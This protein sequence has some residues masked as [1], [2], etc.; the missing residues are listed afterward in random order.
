[1]GQAKLKR[2]AEAREEVV[3]QALAAMSTRVAS[4]HPSVQFMVLDVHRVDEARARLSGLPANI[5]SLLSQQQQA[6]EQFAAVL[7]WRT[8]E[9]FEQAVPISSAG[10][11]AQERLVEFV[12]VSAHSRGYGW[13][14][15]NFLSEEFGRQI[16][17]IRTAADAELKPY[18]AAVA[19]EPALRYATVPDMECFEVAHSTDS[20]RWMRQSSLLIRALDRLSA[21]RRLFEERFASVSISFTGHESDAREIFEIEQGASVIR[22]VVAAVGHW[23]WF[24]RPEESVLWI[25]ALFASGK[26]SVNTRRE[27]SFPVDVDA[28]MRSMHHESFCLTSVAVS[29]GIAADSSLLAER[30]EQI[31]RTQVGILRMLDARQRALASGRDALISADTLIQEVQQQNA[32][33]TPLKEVCTILDRSSIGKLGL[34][35][36]LESAGAFPSAEVKAA[37]LDWESSAAP[38]AVIRRGTTPDDGWSVEHISDE[39]MHLARA[40]DGLLMSSIQRRES[41]SWQLLVSNEMRTKLQS[42]T[43]PAVQRLMKVAGV[44]PH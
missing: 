25:G 31:A 42:S 7:W 32:E 36:L 39:G 41:L 3:R 8:P 34:N 40:V 1:M 10:T 37:L 6:N 19:R 44:Q 4:D 27:M 21:N 23:R 9:G 2:D 16:E 29:L 43:G 20:D 35:M 30:G 22:A 11:E 14:L 17:R 33:K 5:D 24:I 28:A 18:C 12:Q 13:R 26:A 15:A 38:L